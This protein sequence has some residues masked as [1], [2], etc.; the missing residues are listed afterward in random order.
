MRAA[1]F[2][3][4]FLL[5]GCGAPSNDASV[6]PAENARGELRLDWGRSVGAFS[7]W[8]RPAHAGG[9]VCAV[10]ARGEAFFL[11][12][13]T[14]GD[15]AE[16][17][18][19]FDGGGVVSGGAGCDGRTIAAARED[20]VLAVYD[21][22]GEELWRKEFNARITSPPLVDGGA[23]FLLGQDGRLG[24]YSARRGEELWTFVSPLKNLL[25]TPLDSSPS[26]A[27]ELIY[28]GIDNGAA[29][30]LRREDGRVR[31]ITRLAAARS[32]NSFSNILD[33]TT[34]AFGGGLVCAASYQ[35]H[36]GCM[37]DSDGKLL[38]RKPLSAVRRAAMDLDGARVFAV[39][40]DGEVHAYTARGGELLW[41]E[42]LAEATS[43]AFVRGALI[44]GFRDNKIAAL[45]PDDGR[46]LAVQTMN[47]GITHLE[48]LTEESVLG[49]T[50]GGEIF[51]MSF[52]F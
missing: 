19:M 31:W 41:K 20:G 15:A 25:R 26:S 37:D 52:V 47:G 21:S 8:L 4:L 33:V 23:L 38:W 11:D 22:G 46:V 2:G 50:I 18:R 9:T 42:K 17:F 3:L 30:A 34:P 44:V 35:G 49:A 27:G 40:L 45:A 24:A 32:S 43:A 12:A 48:R 13:N 5:G 36:V 14:G 28:A 16:S 10:N 51:R 7:E 39:S 1:F 29:A 6:V